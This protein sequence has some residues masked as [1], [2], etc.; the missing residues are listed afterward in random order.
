MLGLW[1]RLI[2]ALLIWS[3]SW[4]KPFASQ[5]SASSF[6]SSWP[7]PEWDVPWVGA[8]GAAPVEWNFCWG[9]TGWFLAGSE[10][11][12][13]HKP[14]PISIPV[15]FIPNTWNGHSLLSR[16]KKTGQ[17]KRNRAREDLAAQRNNLGLAEAPVKFDDL[18]KHFGR[19]PRGRTSGKSRGLGELGFWAWGPLG[20]LGLVLVSSK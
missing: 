3:A 4:L 15:R 18:E 1:V 2:W 20:L 13:P 9:Q 6:A 10:G 5:L 12:T 19:K 8:A 7:L 16:S 11:M 14:S 17:E